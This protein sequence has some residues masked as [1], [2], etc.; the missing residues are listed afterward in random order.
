MSNNVEQ[1]NEDPC[2]LVDDANAPAQ[3]FFIFK[4]S[5][6]NIHKTLFHLS[7]DLVVQYLPNLQIR[8]VSE[9]SEDHSKKRLIPLS[10]ELEKY[11]TIF[12]HR[13]NLVGSG[14]HRSRFSIQTH[15]YNEYESIKRKE[16]P[17]LVNNLQK[18]AL[19]ELIHTAQVTGT[20]SSATGSVA[21]AGVSVS[22]GGGSETSY[23][24]NPNAKIEFVLLPSKCAL[25]IDSNQF[26][27]SVDGKVVAQLSSR[28]DCGLYEES[29]NYIIKDCQLK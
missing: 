14:G 24:P 18:S 12:E 28:T 10:G 17:F 6:D 9:V 23:L 7:G 8:K 13:E 2:S 27:I 15:H 22:G 21:G 29:G 26:K 19:V 3:G 5:E 4:V 1:S 11:R 25:G 16:G 20:K